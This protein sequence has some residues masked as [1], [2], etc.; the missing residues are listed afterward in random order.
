MRGKIFVSAGYKQFEKCGL[1]HFLS[2]PQCGFRH[3]RENFSVMQARILHWMETGVDVFYPNG[4]RGGKAN[5][6][7]IRDSRPAWRFRRPRC[8]RCLTRGRRDG[9][10]PLPYDPEDDEV[11]STRGNSPTDFDWREAREV[12]H[13]SL[14]E[15][16]F[17]AARRARKW[18]RG[19]CVF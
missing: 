2:R 5:F 6:P 18:W 3:H 7:L 12:I 8:V 14:P 1:R 19:C 4:P 11:I 13:E 9:R 16:Q 15:N 10:R 17:S